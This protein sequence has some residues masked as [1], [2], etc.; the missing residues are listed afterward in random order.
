MKR[1]AVF[2]TFLLSIMACLATPVFAKSSIKPGY[3]VKFNLDLNAFPDLTE[4]L[5]IFEATHDENLKVY[6]FDTPE[7]TFRK[8]HYIHRLRVYEGDKKANLTYKKVFPGME[9][10][11]AIE[12][13][14][15]K[16]FHGDM[17]HYK[18][19][20]DRKERIDTFSISRKEKFKKNNQ[21]NFDDIN[22][23]YAI[24]L[25]KEEAPKKYEGWDNKIWYQE[26][27]NDTIPYGPASVQTYTGYFLG[28]EADIE[29][30]TYQGDTVVEIST[31]TAKKSEADQIE[32]AWFQEL[33]HLNWLSTDQ[34]S[35]TNFVMDR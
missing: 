15:S 22:P 34:A 9:I 28:T 10:T 21:I 7:Q 2:F 26:T 32:K 23:S 4:I 19:E 25:F 13:A 3:E 29:I 14:Y 8:N 1:V 30:W 11:D 27:L 16:G 5:Q 33:S 6:Y 12:E 20:N 35:K 31:K 24:S 18:F 17:N